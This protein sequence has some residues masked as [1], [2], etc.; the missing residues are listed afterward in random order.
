MT[1]RRSAAE[2][3][4]AFTK[5]CSSDDLA[6]V[7]G[8]NGD[9]LNYDGPVNRIVGAEPFL[10]ALACGEHLQ[11]PRERIHTDKPAFDTDGLRARQPAR[12]AS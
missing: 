5:A 8:F 11:I 12:T 2:I 1:H 4:V 7:A 3:A 6:R 10:A 9:D